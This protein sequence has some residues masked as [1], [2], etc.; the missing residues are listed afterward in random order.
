MNGDGISGAMMW[1]GALMVFTPLVAAGLVI[2]VWWFQ[3]RRG[4][5]GQERP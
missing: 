3:K 2:G 4:P 1:V 5:G